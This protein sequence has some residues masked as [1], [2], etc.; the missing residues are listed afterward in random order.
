MTTTQK[1]RAA[2]PRTRKIVPAAD[3][4]Q[5]ILDAVD[6]L[7][8]REGA[9]SVGIDAVVKRAGVNK[10]SLYRQ[11][12]SKDALLLHYLEGRDAL[13]WSKFDA[14][15]AKHPDAP[16]AQLMQLFV[17]LAERTRKPTY[18][19]CPFVNIAAEFPDPEHP[20]RQAVARNKAQLLKRLVALTK[21]AGARDPA[22][23]ARGLALLIEGGYTASQTFE[24]GHP[25]LKALPE[26]AG[27][28]IEA[29]CGG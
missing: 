28:L 19:G 24:P 9:R 13:F 18:R 5:Q 4:Q 17:D 15:L 1:T 26:T 22:A 7:F 6:E 29:A 16:R 20:A 3:A 23:L 14:S 2:A 10:M 21:A 25:I 12:E 11:F 8:Y 27:I